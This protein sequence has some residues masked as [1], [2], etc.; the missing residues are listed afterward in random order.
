[1]HPDSRRRC[2][3]GK[4]LTIVTSAERLIAGKNPK[5]GQGVCQLADIQGRH[6]ATSPRATVLVITCSR[7]AAIIRSWLS[8]Q[9]TSMH[10]SL[11]RECRY[12]KED[13]Y[14]QRMLF[15]F[16]PQVIVGQKATRQSSNSY[17]LTD[18]TTLSGDV[19]FLTVGGQPNTRFLNGLGILDANG[20]IKVCRE[21]S[22]ICCRDISHTEG[23]M[24]GGCGL[25]GGMISLPARSS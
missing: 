16:G 25:R 17:V 20:Y 14:C 10:T 23:R 3:P 22:S 5:I 13:E 6:G 15:N 8:T 24:L 12:C 9:T 19:V 21:L 18:G 2:C 7:T 11:A 4:K 1:M